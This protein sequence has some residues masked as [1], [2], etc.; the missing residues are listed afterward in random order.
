[1][2]EMAIGET[3]LKVIDEQAQKNHFTVVRS[4]TLRLGRMNAFERKNLEL[5]LK[6]YK[7]G[8]FAQTRFDIEA[9]PVG[10]ECPS[11]AHQ[12][13]DERFDDF[14]F[15]HRTAHAPGLY[16]PPACPKCGTKG[17]TIVSGQE[18]ELVSIEGE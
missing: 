12:Y 11:C 18:M 15:A 17:A 2:H 13:E 16:V 10:L 1:M 7:E 8:V 9:V 4:A 3:I 14:D 6:T 5:C